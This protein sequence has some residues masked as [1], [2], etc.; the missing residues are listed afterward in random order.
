MSF[1]CIHNNLH[2]FISTNLQLLI[3]SI[4]MVFACVR[5]FIH[6]HIY[7]FILWS[8]VAVFT[9]YNI[10]QLEN[11]RGGSYSPRTGRAK[12][13]RNFTIFSR[14]VWCNMTQNLTQYEAIFFA[15]WGNILPSIR[16]YWTQYV[17]LFAR[18]WS[19]IYLCS[20]LMKKC[21]YI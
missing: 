9:S 15:V 12:S 1:L 8:P 17:A 16:H 6:K 13:R 20:I 14:N 5:N 11:F 18:Y 4:K 7:F 3:S 10:Y 21:M 19:S 2:L